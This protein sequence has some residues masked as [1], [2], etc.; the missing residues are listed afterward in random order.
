MNVF[1]FIE[2]REVE[3]SALD[4]I[5]QR[6][7]SPILFTSRYLNEGHF[8][9]GIDLQRFD[10]VYYVDTF[11][12]NAMLDCIRHNA[13]PVAAVLGSYDEVMIPAAEIADA[14]QLPHPSLDGLNNAFNKE[15]VRTELNARGYSQP[16][17]RFFSVDG[18]P[19]LPAIPYPLVIKP[20]RDAGSFSVFLCRTGEQYRA[21]VAKIRSRD[22]LSMLGSEHRHF[23]MEQFIEGPFYG[24]ELLYNAGRWQVIAINRLFVSAGDSPCI[25]GISQPSDL[26]PE[27][28]ALAA[29]QVVHWAEALGLQGGA[30]NVEFIYAADGPVLVEINLRVS[31]ARVAQQVAL[32]TGINMM[33]H[34]VDFACGIERPLNFAP[35]ARYPFVAD[36]FIFSADGAPP[37]A[38]NLN[39]NGPFFIAGQVTS[40]PNLA[41][42]ARRNF[43]SIIGHVLAHGQTCHEAMDHAAAIVR[44]LRIKTA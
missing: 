43:G 38:M 22:T 30:L 15:R 41:P 18:I 26:S 33:E 27:C 21:A 35:T 1:L 2:A 13:M 28:R 10:K 14:L 20:T 7:L 25:T 36:A 34:L 29:G 44:T 8:Y 4:D 32:T 19:I 31:G 3:F 23:L 17:Y 37:T 39:Q 12:S 42:G 16:L 40:Q 5:R 6:G 11:D 9:H 24:A